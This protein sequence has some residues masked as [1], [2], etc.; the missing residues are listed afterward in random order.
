MDT[1]NYIISKAFEQDSVLRLGFERKLISPGAVAKHIIRENPGKE[2]N[3]ESL[4]T[5][6]RRYSKR[7]R[8]NTEF[9]GS[10]RKVLARSYLHVRNSIVK[11]ELNK[12]EAT[13]ELINKSF[14]INKIYNN[15]IFRLIKGHSVLHAIVEES[16]I[17]D[18]L[19]L[20]EGKIIGTHTGLCEF[21]IVMPFE[22]RKTPG[23]ILTLLNELSM[24]NINIVQAFSC[25]EEINIIVDDEDNQRAYN[26]LTGLFRKCREEFREELPDISEMLRVG[27]K[28]GPATVISEKV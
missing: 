20:F 28:E 4:R 3:L 10:A 5:T 17:K 27:A 22:S 13:L 11:V 15:D 19:S 24:S 1:I 16:N 21:I 14:H 8:K 2:L 9:L 6:I 18:I 12:D 25:G 7:I 23:I 26:M